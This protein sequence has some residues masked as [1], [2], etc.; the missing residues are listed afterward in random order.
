MNYPEEDRLIYEAAE[1]HR[2][3]IRML[4]K[5]EAILNR[6][7]AIKKGSVAE[8]LRYC[9]IEKRYTITYTGG[10][11][12]CSHILVSRHSKLLGIKVPWQKKRMPDIVINPERRRNYAEKE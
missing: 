3:R 8:A 4:R 6:A 10:V 1:G 5:Y 7:R 11:L 12:D 9:L 2:F